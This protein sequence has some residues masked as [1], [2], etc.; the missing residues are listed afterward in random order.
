MVDLI[1]W[2][3]ARLAGKA[4]FAFNTNVDVVKRVNA[5]EIDFR[6]LPGEL[7]C[8][9]DCM[10]RGSERE[11]IVSE[12]T[13]RFLRERIGFNE[14][15]VGGQAGI[16]ACAA[17]KL[18]VQSFLHVAEK[19]ETQLSVL[20]KNVFVAGE[21]GFVS[22]REAKPSGTSATHF[23]LEFSQGDF[24]RGKK[25]P[26]SNRF[27]ASHDASGLELSIDKCFERIVS[28]KILEIDKAI[29]SG[30]HLLSPKFSGRVNYA[31]ELV[32]NWKQKNPRLRLHLELGEFQDLSVLKKVLN[33]FAPLCDSIGMNEIE[34][35]Q[36]VKALDEMPRNEFMD[37][38]LLLTG[39]RTAVVHTR[40]Y[41]FA[42]SKD[43]RE[44]D[45]TNALL[46]ASLA[47]CFK[48][49]TGK[50]ASLSELEKC[51]PGKASEQAFVK[52]KEF[53]KQKLDCA[54]GFAPGF[55]IEQPKQTVGVGDVFAAGFLLTI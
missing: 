52:E 34:L 3:S 25:I 42:L 23:I 33:D 54:K 17:S 9:E 30:F 14:L 5:S 49:S 55:T 40:D 16:S 4:L 12:D 10:I 7:S 19:G 2:A 47:A 26:F 31:A 35:R 11:V 41:S 32:S 39:V 8:L 24:A 50:F 6:G 51:N 13:M 18:G 48:A 21:N 1:E 29:V 15:Q 45:L 20:D 43:K 44:E 38:R 46:F 37:A 27:I 36:C 53:E 28:E 22:V